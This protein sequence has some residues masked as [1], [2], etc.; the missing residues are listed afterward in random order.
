M[1]GIPP[2]LPLEWVW[3]FLFLEGECW[4]SVMSST[5]N[6]LHS[7]LLR[8]SNPLFVLVNWRRLTFPCFW[9]EKTTPFSFWKQPHLPVCFSKWI[10]NFLLNLLTLFWPS[11]R[12]FLR[13]LLLWRGRNN[14][15]RWT[16]DMISTMELIW[17]VF[18]SLTPPWASK[19]RTWPL[20]STKST[21]W[22]AS[23]NGFL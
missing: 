7:H 10:P 16:V 9:V 19:L 13:I 20:L 1:Y 21:E 3:S 14:E 22:Y 2:A 11:P 4:M 18:W 23:W 17:L 15:V 8:I 5:R 6:V 12:S